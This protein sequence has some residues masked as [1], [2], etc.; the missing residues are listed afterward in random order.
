MKCL[1]KW[2]EF[3]RKNYIDYSGYR[4]LKIIFKCEKCDKNRIKKYY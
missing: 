2:K 1:H 4:V 3:E